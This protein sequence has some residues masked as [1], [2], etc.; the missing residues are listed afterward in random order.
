[1]ATRLTVQPEF[2]EKATLIERS[3]DIRRNAWIAVFAV[4]ALFWTVVGLTV[5]HLWG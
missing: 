5:W 4:S 2:R 1:M 3:S